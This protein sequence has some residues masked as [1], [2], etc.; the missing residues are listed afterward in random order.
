ML[1]GADHKHCP[2]SNQLAAAAA[3]CLDHDVV[4]FD[5]MRGH[6]E[7][8]LRQIAVECKYF[9]CAFASTS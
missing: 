6:R 2:C 7:C 9:G 8:L 1:A 4:G 3:E 5:E